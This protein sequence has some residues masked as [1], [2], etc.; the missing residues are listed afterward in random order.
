MNILVINSGSSSIKFQLIQMPSEELTCSGMVERVGHPDA[1]LKYKTH[2]T[3]FQETLRIDTHKEG[4]KKI[5]DL[6]LDEE[7][8][9]IRKPDEIDV[10]GHRVV[11]GGN[12]FS[13][14]RKYGNTPP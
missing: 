10:V 3:D 8:G 5:V 12:I 6:L 9:V 11:H 1:I 2:E 4:L 14:I 7:I 13:N